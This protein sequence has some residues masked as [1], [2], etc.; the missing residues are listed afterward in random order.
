MK[1]VSGFF[2]ISNTD[3]DDFNADLKKAIND[4]QDLK[5]EIEIQYQVNSFPNGQIVYSALILGRMEE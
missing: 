1:K 4:L 3:S 2:N 5:Q